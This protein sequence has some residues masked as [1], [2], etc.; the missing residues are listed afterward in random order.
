[1]TK[2]IK[3]EQPRIS[4]F[5]YTDEQINW[6]NENAPIMQLKQIPIE[7][8]KRF[9]TN[10]TY[11]QIA[12]A[13]RRIYHWKPTRKLNR[14]R[15]L[16][17]QEH[18][19]YMLTIYKGR[20]CKET[21]KMINDKFG[22]NYTEQQVSSFLGNNHLKNGV[23][24][25]FKK[26]H[27]AQNK[28]KK[29]ADYMSPESQAKARQTCF[30]KGNISANN[31]PIGT[32]SIRRDKDRKRMYYN[33]IKVKDGCQQENFMLYARYVYEQAHNVKL[34]K[35]QLILHLDG[36]SL[37]DNIDNLM[38]IEQKENAV[39]NKEFKVSDDPNITKASVL[40]IRIDQKLK[41]I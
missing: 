10:I 6:L 39:L 9:G 12:S 5:V 1:M 27:K 11:W 23:D 29:W 37:N 30:K 18:I 13:N 28:G 32:I 21:A 3:N 7:F 20:L 26:G 41:G 25:N 19:D 15:I 33:W 36:N 35:N 14:P 22:S 24:T 38:L 31:V 40:T 34:K 2:R 8:N 16:W 17:K 4:P